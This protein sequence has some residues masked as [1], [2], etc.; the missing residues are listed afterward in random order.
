MSYKIK[1]YYPLDSGTYV[2]YVQRQMHDPE[3]DDAPGGLLSSA[4]AHIFS[5][6]SS[7]AWGLP[8]AIYVFLTFKYNGFTSAFCWEIESGLLRELHH[9]V[10]KE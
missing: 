5:L 6:L 3:K 10:Q 9:W 2:Y 1:F 4:G 8:M 7:L